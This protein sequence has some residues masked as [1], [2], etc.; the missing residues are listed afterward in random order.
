MSPIRRREPNKNRLAKVLTIS[1]GLLIV[2]LLSEFAT[3]IITIPS[4]RSWIMGIFRLAGRYC[5]KPVCRAFVD[6]NC[7]RH[8]FVYFA[9]RRV[10]RE[11]RIIQSLFELIE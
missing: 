4:F 6:R 11:K 10:N 7:D 3:S 5:S 1:P 2:S 8:S 9:D